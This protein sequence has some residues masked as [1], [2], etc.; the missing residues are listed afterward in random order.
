MTCV[1]VLSAITPCNENGT[2]HRNDR[3]EVHFKHKRSRALKHSKAR[4]EG[5]IEKVFLNGIGGSDDPPC[6]AAGFPRLRSLDW[7]GLI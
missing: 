6:V 5:E 7:S 2:N 3:P 4:C 1:G